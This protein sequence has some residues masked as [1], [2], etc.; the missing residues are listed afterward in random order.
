MRLIQA[1]INGYKHLRDLSV[2]FVP[3]EKG[4]PL[5]RDG[6][7]IRFLIGLNGSGKS[8]F[9]E[10][11]CLVFSRLAQDELPGFDFSLQYEIWRD[12]RRRV[13]EVS[14]VGGGRPDIHV[15]TEG[16]EGRLALSSFAEHRNL[17][18][19]Y[20]FVCASGNNNN[21]F[22]IAVRSPRDALHGEL[23]DASLLG[24]SQNSPQRQREE[25]AR[26]LGALRRLEEDPIC[27]FI[28]EH[29]AVLALAAFLAVLPGGE[30]APCRKQILEILDSLPQPV[31]FSLTL[32]LER[33]DAFEDS[34]GGLFPSPDGSDG[35]NLSHWTTPRFYRDENGDEETS[36]GDQVVTFLFKPS[37]A[38]EKPGVY[39]KS[40][41]D[42]FA[43]PIRLLSE[44]I[45]AQNLG[46][47]KEAHLSFRLQGAEDLL[48]EN[49]LSEGE[50]MLLVRLGLLAMGRQEESGQCLYLLDE[51]DVYLNE[52]WNIDFVSIIHQIYQGA[53][54]RHELLVATHSS[55]ILTDAFPEQLYYFREEHGSVKCR[56]IRA[57]TFG[58][59]RNEI[60]QALFQTSHSVGNFSYSKIEELLQKA[61][62]AGELEEQLKNV[63]SGYLRLRLLE[64][65]RRMR[66]G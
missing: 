37:E 12:G 65:L 28:D 55:L 41:T 53:A 45:R 5:F 20:V 2:S 40:L 30:A 25:I 3:P 64:R 33:L 10:G 6:I 9:L 47:I 29:T 34:C 24:K 36:Q 7:P 59:S 46:V 44:L 54:F 35:P 61:Q 50:Y 11:L 21:F 8:A 51:P 56:N 22:D 57:S 42:A 66:E 63:G 38:G 52:R 4:N 31:S 60:M 19:D 27:L 32:D 26:A 43:S 17:L 58:G 18:P 48:E 62:S 39:V 16:Q 23:F 15:F 13:V 1:S 49:A 14:G